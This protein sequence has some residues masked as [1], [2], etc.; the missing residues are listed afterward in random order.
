M[1]LRLAILLAVSALGACTTVGPD[2]ARP[3]EPVDQA[4][5]S[6]QELAGADAAGPQSVLGE[7]PQTRWWTVF[8][9][10]ELD[11][12][13]DRALA[14]N[15]SLAAAN[16]TLARAY[17]ELGEVRGQSL[18]QVDANA[19]VD[20][21][22][23]NLAAFGFEGA[24]PEFTLYTLGGG[25]SYDL[26][27]FGGNR[28]RVEAASARAEAQLRQTEAAHLALAGR[29]VNQALAQAAIRARIA[30]AEG[31]VAEDQRN[32]DLID[33]RR[34]GGDGTMVE[35][36]NARSQL[37]A[38][39]AELPPLRQ[40]LAEANHMLAILLGEAP[41]AGDVPAFDLDSLALPQA[42]PVALPSQLVRHRPDILQA[43]A[44]LHAA[45]AS[46]GI[47]TAA[48]YPDITLG[49]SVTQ[50]QPDGVDHLFTDMFRGYN[51]FAGV[52]API[53]HGGTLKA[54][55]QAAEAEAQAAQAR[56]E[57][58]VIEAFG[59][60]A[61]LLTALRHDADAVQGQREAVDVAARS[62]H[63]SRRSFE[64]GNS[65][66]LQVLDSERIY[67]RALSGLVEA[68]A[69]Q[70][71]DVTRLFVATAGGWTGGAA[72]TEPAR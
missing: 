53:F 1:N 23:F 50:G 8:H 11:A 36:L 58:T 59:Q 40:Q 41:A 54:R 48:L 37:A 68:R 45:T 43:E 15:R 26:D 55:R 10:P 6:P 27:L 5:L 52:T 25:V 35:V 3:P 46:V 44:D 32:V 21:Q 49:A 67:Q 47:A 17:A 31:L 70:Y 33:R 18:P 24:N 71:R 19:K 4:Y 56:Y 62:L 39:L 63:L 13:V 16:A 66:V 42:I 7:G 51:L 12:L 38:D 34:R 72:T 28:R 65:G 22:Q 29:V 61:D 64:V 30:V 2:F 9:S 57:Q 69:R 60:V 20:Q 14:Q